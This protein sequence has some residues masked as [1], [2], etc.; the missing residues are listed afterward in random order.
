MREAREDLNNH[1]K[2]QG[3]RM[4]QQANQTLGGGNDNTK[5]GNVRLVGLPTLP[6]EEADHIGNDVDELSKVGKIHN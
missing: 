5:G 6:N 4:E 3:Q 2:L 1:F